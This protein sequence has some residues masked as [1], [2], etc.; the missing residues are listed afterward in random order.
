MSCKDFDQSTHSSESSLSTWRFF[1][2]LAVQ[3]VQMRNMTRVFAGRTCPRYISHVLTMCK[4]KLKRILKYMGNTHMLIHVRK[5]HNQIY[6][7]YMVSYMAFVLSLFVSHP[8]CF[9][10]YENTPIQIYRKFH[11][12]NLKIFR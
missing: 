1:R 8:S 11:L 4:D 6:A 2:S 7:K 12:Q 5:T 10:H 3:R 9:W